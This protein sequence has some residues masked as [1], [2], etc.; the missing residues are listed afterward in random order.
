[1]YLQGIQNVYWVMLPRAL[2]FYVGMALAVPCVAFIAMFYRSAS[3][4]KRYYVIT[5]Y[6][7]FVVWW[8]KVIC[9]TS[10][11]IEGLENMLDH[12]SIIISSHQS[13][14]ETLLIQLIAKPQVWVLKQELLRIP[15][16]SIG[17][18]MLEPIVLD[19]SMA[20]RSL[21]K[22]VREGCEQLAKGRWVVVFPEGTRTSVGEEKKY[23][24]GVGLLAEKS[25]VPIIPIAHNAGY[26]WP[27][28]TLI[29]RPGVIQVV[30]GP[31]IYPAAGKTATMITAEAEEWIKNTSKRLL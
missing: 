21:R 9:N 10:Y 27:R 2:L 3:F 15:I 11:T 26:F 20:A 4:N 5:R 19:R 23:L 29:K 18:A 25:G 1:M 14:W 12:P 24:P 13:V 8:L 31:A 30:I 17:L 6:A 28:N 22:M 7:C 16:F